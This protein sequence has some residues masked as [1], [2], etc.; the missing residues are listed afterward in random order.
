MIA[1]VAYAALVALAT[2][3]AASG[4]CAEALLA[5]PLPSREE[6]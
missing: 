5:L 3:L 2:L 6:D 1:F 4:F